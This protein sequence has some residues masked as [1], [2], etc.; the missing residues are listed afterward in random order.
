MFSEYS[1][2]WLA[3]NRKTK[4]G[5]SFIDSIGW[6]F[7]VISER[8]KQELHCIISKIMNINSYIVSVVLS[9]AIKNIVSIL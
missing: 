3:G 7:P 1:W 4:R 9:E 5:G 8:N 2:I 6:S